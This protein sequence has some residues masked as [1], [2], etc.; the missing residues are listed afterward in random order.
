[1]TQHNFEAIRA[2]LESFPVKRIQGIVRHSHGLASAGSFDLDRDE[3]TNTKPKLVDYAVNLAMINTSI[4]HFMANITDAEPIPS[5]QEPA[6]APSAPS[7]MPAPSARPAANPAAAG[8]AAAMIQQAMALLMS[9]ARP[10]I[11]EEA[12]KRIVDEAVSG[13][14][15]RE[16]VVKIADKPDYNSPAR[17]HP[18]FEK[19]LR[20]AAQGI[21]VLLV[22]PAGC[23]KTH[24][25]H[26]V[27]KALNRPFGSVSYS[28][29]ASESWLLGR[30]LPTGEGGK[31]EY[32]TS[33]FAE[34][35]QV[36]SVFLHDELDAADANM[37][38]TT[39]SA[40]AN[41][42]FD[43]P[44][45]GSRLTRHAEAVQI[46]SA[47]TFGNGADAMYVGRAQLDA[48]TLDRW[49]IVNVDYD[50]ALEQ[51]LAPSHVCQFVWKLREGASRAKLRRVIS[52][53]M[54]QKGAAALSAGLSWDEVKTD[55]LSGW[56]K[57]E[58]AKVGA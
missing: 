17:Q 34:L 57:D 31:F 32:Q 2:K 9:G 40:L 14:K 18:S 54:V 29:G 1:M 10:G 42:G 50:R 37:L 58:L 38:I 45:S 16:I 15:P 52:T 23:G 53:R 28:A 3:R 19:V 41:G 33:R 20:L 47:N 27:A 49:Y 48:A 24:L 13:I 6:P 25:A 51:E 44:V 21:N 35:Y 56:T 8:D 46:G 22:G 4:A 43:N 26:E 30:L 5:A 11:D 55:L 36:P 12:V 39:N 7:P